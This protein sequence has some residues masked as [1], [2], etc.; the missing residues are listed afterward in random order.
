MAVNLNAPA[1]AIPR[2]GRRCRAGIR[3]RPGI[4]KQDRHD[5]MLMRLA[6][7]AVVAGVFTQN[8]FAAAPVQVC[9]R[10][11]GG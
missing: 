8:S 2:A 7:G 5:L 4:R 3:R 9:R 6:P 1:P 10:H 11:L